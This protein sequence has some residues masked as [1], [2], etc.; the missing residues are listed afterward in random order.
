ML[1]P[2]QYGYIVAAYDVFQAIAPKKVVSD[3][4][5]PRRVEPSTESQRSKWDSYA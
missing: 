4:P 2:V 5:K 1:I 3:S